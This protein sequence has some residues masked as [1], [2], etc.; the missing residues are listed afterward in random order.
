MLVTVQ[1]EFSNHV[2]IFNALSS[3]LNMLRTQVLQEL[4]KSWCTEQLFPTLT[5]APGGG[6]GKVQLVADLS[7]LL[8]R[9]Q[10]SFRRWGW[11]LAVL[12]GFFSSLVSSCLSAVVL[13]E[14]AAFR[15]ADL[16][17][18]EHTTVAVKGVAKQQN[19]VFFHYAAEGAESGTFWDLQL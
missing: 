4:K 3:A 5:G 19:Q 9:S 6:G 7:H 12:L 16:H 18:Q 17:N 2:I 13:W 15:T 8:S 1:T 10:L 14:V 11:D